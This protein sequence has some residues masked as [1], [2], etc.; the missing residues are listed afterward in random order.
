MILLFLKQPKKSLE[1][2]YRLSPLQLCSMLQTVQRTEDEFGADNT[3]KAKQLESE[4]VKMQDRLLH[5]RGL[6]RDFIEVRLGSGGPVTS[7][8]SSNAF[9]A[10]GS[11]LLR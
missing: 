3:D 5:G 1:G 9:V 6:F 8:C 11:N 4:I 7:A 10:A 2:S